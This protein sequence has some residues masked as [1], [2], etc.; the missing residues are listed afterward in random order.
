MTIESFE[1]EVGQ[2]TRY[3]QSKQ[4]WMFLIWIA[5]FQPFF[6]NSLVEC[7]SLSP[8]KELA[9]QKLVAGLYETVVLSCL[10]E[11]VVPDIDFFELLRFV[12][13][14]E[15]EETVGHLPPDA[16]VLVEDG[17]CPG[18][19]SQALDDPM[20]QAKQIAIGAIRV[21]TSCCHLDQLVDVD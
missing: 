3:G 9:D 13:F 17:K 8:R 5:R 10:N 11:Y 1:L 19:Q 21:L 4:A 2:D 7:N 14:Q 20:K 18:K 15:V 6:A 16:G 12:V